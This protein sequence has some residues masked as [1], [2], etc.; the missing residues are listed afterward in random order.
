MSELKVN[1]IRTL[2][3]QMVVSVRTEAPSSGVW[4]QGDIVYT[5]NPTALGFIGWVCV[6]SGSPGTWKTFGPISA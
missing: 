1:E 6:A 5:N 4:N 2:D 3:G